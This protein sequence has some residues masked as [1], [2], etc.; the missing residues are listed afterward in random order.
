MRSKLTKTIILIVFVVFLGINNVEA[1]TCTYSKITF[2]DSQNNGY[3]LSDLLDIFTG[4]RERYII[5]IDSFGNTTKITHRI[6][7]YPAIW[8]G[9]T[10]DVTS[11]YNVDFTLC[12]SG[13]SF[14][15]NTI[16][17]GNT[18][19]GDDNGWNDGSQYVGTL[20]PDGDLDTVSCG[21]ITD[22]PKGIPNTTKIIYLLLQIG[23]PIALV[24][25]G[26]IDLMKAITA[27]KEDEIKKGQQTFI[28][29]LI[30]AAIV[31]FVF[32]IVK[33]L[34]SFLADNTSVGEC[35][36]CFIKGDCTTTSDEQPSNQGSGGGGS[37]GGGGGGNRPNATVA[38][39]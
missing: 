11:Q 32:A 13:I 36:K 23:I 18:Y 7:N 14:D 28:K 24:V 22:I 15:G 16:V 19:R 20:T 39:Y 31:F 37:V 12:P 29:R 35:L 3:F 26:M 5:E 2:N 9:T 25:F 4:V 21:E 6:T 1:V 38:P 30:S 34:S 8:R 33:T 10:E 17:A 27:Q